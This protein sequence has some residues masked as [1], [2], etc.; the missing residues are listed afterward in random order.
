M[1]FFL[2]T[3]TMLK[4]SFRVIVHIRLQSCID[5]LAAGFM[6]FP[7]TCKQGKPQLLDNAISLNDPIKDTLH[8]SLDYDAH[9]FVSTGLCTT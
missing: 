7:I 9:C 1:H 3:D 2:V 5:Y 4:N 6:T 8:N